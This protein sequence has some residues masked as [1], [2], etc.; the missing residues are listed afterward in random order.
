MGKVQ[1]EACF[2]H[3]GFRKYVSK[4]ELLNYDNEFNKRYSYNVK[5]MIKHIE[6]YVDIKH[7]HKRLNDKSEIALFNFYLYD[8]SQRYSTYNIAW[9]EYKNG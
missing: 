8:F 9:K 6:K 5:F 1:K 2:L 4:D 7:H 3:Q